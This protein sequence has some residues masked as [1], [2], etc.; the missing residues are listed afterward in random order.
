MLLRLSLQPLASCQRPNYSAVAD[1]PMVRVILLLPE[2]QHPALLV[3]GVSSEH[4]LWLLFLL[5]IVGVQA[6]IF[7][8]SL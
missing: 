4:S 3:V 7:A 8:A 6:L 1:L 5:C 2:P